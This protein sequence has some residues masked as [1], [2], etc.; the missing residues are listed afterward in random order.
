M[1]QQVLQLKQ[2]KPTDRHAG[3]FDSFRD[4]AMKDLN[5]EVVRNL[6]C[7]VDRLKAFEMMY[8]AQ[9]RKLEQSIA[10][11]REENAE[12]AA[13]NDRLYAEVRNLRNEQGAVE[14]RARMNLG[15]IREDET[16]FLVVEN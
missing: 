7:E 3:R 9:Q 2:M 15:L 5:A 16:F 1:Q 14:E 13:R 4:Y 10:E 11:Q 8:H 6:E 12:L